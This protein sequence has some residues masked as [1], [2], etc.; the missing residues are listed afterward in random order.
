ML[1]PKPEQTQKPTKADYL[2]SV[3]DNVIQTNSEILQD[4][5]SESSVEDEDMCLA[6]SYEFA[7]II[8]P[9]SKFTDDVGHDQFFSNSY[10]APGRRIGNV[11]K[12]QFIPSLKLGTESPM[13][14]LFKD[15]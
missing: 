5:G 7:N 4:L 13:Q 2:T 6:Q 1:D 14:T 8:S 15:A 9:K 10:Q 12:P 11:K 3:R